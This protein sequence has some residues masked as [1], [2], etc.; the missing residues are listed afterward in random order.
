M[1]YIWIR[2]FLC[3][4]EKNNRKIKRELSVEKK[5]YFVLGYP[6]NDDTSIKGAAYQ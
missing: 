5:S 1:Q 2:N 6:T 4:C 3:K